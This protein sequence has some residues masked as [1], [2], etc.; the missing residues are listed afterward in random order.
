MDVPM[1]KVLIES[2]LGAAMPKVLIESAVHM[3]SVLIESAS[4][5][6][7]AMSKHSGETVEKQAAVETIEQI[8]VH[9]GFAV[10]DAA[11][12]RKFGGHS[13]RVSGA[14]WLGRLGF[15]VEQIRTFGRWC[16]DAVVRYLGESHVADMARVRR[17]GALQRDLVQAMALEAPRASGPQLCTALELERFITSLGCL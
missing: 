10:V 7:T 13:L 6:C 4:E 8:G 2:T 3:P 9:C 17:R 1:P 11:G 12:G 14:Q 5:T 16:S 15:E